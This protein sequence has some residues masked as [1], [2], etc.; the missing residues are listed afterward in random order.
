MT[1]LTSIYEERPELRVHVE[2]GE[3]GAH[4]TGIDLTKPIGAEDLGAIKRALAEHGVIS[5]PEQELAHEHLEAFT[6]QLGNFGQNPFVEPLADHPHVVEVRRDPTETLPVFGE[7]WHSDWSFQANPPAFTILH[8]KVVPPTGGDT[9]FADTLRAFSALSPGL[10]SM[11]AGMRAVHTAA[12]PYGTKGYFA[13]ESGRTGMR[14][15]TG[16]EAD[17]QR[18]HPIAPLHPTTGKRALFINQGYTSHVEGLSKE[19]SA[20]L[21]SFLFAHMTSSRFVYRLRWRAQM[22]TVWDN[23]RTI[24]R[25]TG[26][27]DG[28]LR[29]MHRTVVAGDPFPEASS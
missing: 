12:G 13:A 15:R 22:L 20:A 29:L 3:F 10:R 4:L 23:R 6:L 27:Y 17:E 5:F 8:A 25:A 1:E 21:L 28:H 24:H 19:E 26:G 9:Y 2:R 7:G 11:L 14:I 16:A 18:S